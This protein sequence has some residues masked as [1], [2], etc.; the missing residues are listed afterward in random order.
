VPAV[1]ALVGVIILL[2]GVV[3]VCRHFPAP[4]L[5]WWM[6]S[7][8]SLGLE[9]DRRNG[10]VFDIVSCWSISFGDTARCFLLC[11]SSVRRFP[12]LTFK[13]SMYDIVGDS[14]TMT[15]SE[16]TESRHLLAIFF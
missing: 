13:G 7:G 16:P 5:V 9:L 15:F 6:S 4:A 8:E 1:M 2:E 3:E 10:D 12:R 14:K 11:H